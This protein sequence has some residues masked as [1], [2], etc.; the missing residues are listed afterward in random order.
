MTRSGASAPVVVVGGS[1]GALAPLLDI[2][3][4]LP[5]DFGAAVLVVIHLP[6]DQPSVLPTLLG[7]AG[8]LPARHAQSG[9]QLQPG[10]IYVAPPN[11]HLLLADGRV[12]LSYG[13]RENRSR[14][15]IDVLFRSAAYTHGPLVAGVL[16]SGMLDDGTSGVWAVQHFGGTVI[17]QH[18][19]EAEYPDMPLSALRQVPVDDI[20]NARDIA[21]RL[22]AWA[23]VRP[24]GERQAQELRE[25]VHVSD[26]ERRRLAAELGIA[27]EDNAFDWG[28]LNAGP[29]SP[30]TCPECHGVMGQI[31]EGNT[32]RYRCHTGHAYTAG[33]LLSEVRH[34]VEAT[35]WSAVRALDENVMLLEHLGKHLEEA[36]HGEQAEAILTE[37]REVRERAR[38]MRPLTM[39]VS[40]EVQG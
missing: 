16:L 11:Q 4:G 2:V 19:N 13:P 35:L 21:P 37:A 3:A 28:I 39:R 23:A 10:C 26:E 14:P 38:Q 18:P 15:S 12:R 40:A 20:L 6:P 33:T 29:L 5:R 31:K 9:E 30:F 34:S 27:S 8:E 24:T 17:V 25:E 22:V 1:A 7:R 32:T 36:G